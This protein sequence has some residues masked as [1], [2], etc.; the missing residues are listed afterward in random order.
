[1]ATTNLERMY[2]RILKRLKTLKDSYDFDIYDY[3][4]KEAQWQ[5]SYLISCHQ[6][7]GFEIRKKISQMMT[8][9]DLKTIFIVKDSFIKN[10]EKEN[11]FKIE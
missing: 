4:D 7:N 8:A 11:I 2:V 9:N 1:M 3:R 5:Y 6:D 10:F